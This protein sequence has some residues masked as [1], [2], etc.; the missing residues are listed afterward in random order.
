[1][2]IQKTKQAA[3]NAFTSRNLETADTLC[4]QILQSCPDD[5]DVLH[6]LGETLYQT[7]NSEAAATFINRAITLRPRDAGLH[8]SLSNILLALGKTEESIAAGK[9]A[10]RKQSG[11]AALY[12]NLGNLLKCGDRNREAADYY[13]RAIKLHPGY[14]EAHNNLANVLRKLNEPEDAIKHAQ[15]A[16]QLQSDHPGV[17]LTLG[18]AYSD[19][20]DTKNALFYYRRCLEFLPDNPEVNYKIGVTYRR[21]K[22]L[23]EALASFDLAIRNS[24]DYVE[25][26]WEKALACLLMENYAVGW[27]EYEWRLRRGTHTK[28]RFLKPAWDGSSLEGKTILV[29]DERRLGDTFQFIRYLKPLKERGARVILECRPGMGTI[30][31]G[32]TGHDMLIEQISPHTVPDIGF[33]VHTYLQSLP[34]YLQSWRREDIP[35]QIPYLTTDVELT[36][37]WNEKL[38]RE[39]GFKIG[40]CWAG[41]PNRAIDVIRDCP[42]S[43]F[44]TIAEISGVRLY[45]L[46]KAPGNEQAY[47]LPNGMELT[48]LDIVLDKH[49]KFVDTAAVMKNLDLVITVDT[50]IAHLAGALGCRVWTLIPEYPD[51]C[52]LLDGEDT[53]WYPSMQLF[54]QI[55]AGSWKQ[56]LKQIKRA[57]AGLMS[58]RTKKQPDQIE[59]MCDTGDPVSTSK[60]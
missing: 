17:N 52:W 18:N 26:H 29:Q 54:R 34:Y 19:I 11:N 4:R 60:F 43:E 10:I 28:R 39:P 33:D 16:Y 8:Q 24:P 23:P 15:L 50:S 32:C 5:V 55:S 31:Q 51:W 49:A 25:A 37:K 1:M 45:S 6:L 48:R 58:Y 14:V 40:I 53:P 7:G 41:S 56:V 12:Y 59:L 3:L 42:L 22:K 36:R 44:A 35:C 57:V 21:M 2:D 30:L 47:Q 9:Q 38:G 46:Q 20:G 13:L 27:G